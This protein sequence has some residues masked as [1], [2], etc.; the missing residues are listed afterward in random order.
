MNISMR[1]SF[2]SESSRNTITAIIIIAMIA[3]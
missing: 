3:Y 1:V 2:N